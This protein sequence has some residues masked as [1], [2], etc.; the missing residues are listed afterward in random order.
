MGVRCGGWGRGAVLEKCFLSACRLCL[1]QK[2]PGT[3]MVSLG[4]PVTQGAYVTVVLI[5]KSFGTI[6]WGILLLTL[7]RLEKTKRELEAVPLPGYINYLD[8]C[9]RFFVKQ[10]ILMSRA[11]VLCVNLSSVTLDDSCPLETATY[12]LSFFMFLLS[13]CSLILVSP[14]TCSGFLYYPQSPVT[15]TPTFFV[16]TCECHWWNSQNHAAWICYKLLPTWLNHIRP[17]LGHPFTASVSSYF[18]P[19]SPSSLPASSS[20]ALQM[21]SSPVYPKERPACLSPASHLQR[22]S[23]PCESEERPFIL[24]KITR[25]V[26][27]VNCFLDFSTRYL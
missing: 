11:D 13:F 14:W 18:H 17:L 23:F 25:L 20:P 9:R 27:C 16:K 1:I 12:E 15:L 24:D 6:A 4:K 26:C 2:R 22:V 10:L 21:T 7:T 8:L 3:G 19:R 5:G